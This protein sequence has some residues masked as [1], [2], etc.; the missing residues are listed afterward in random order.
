MVEAKAQFHSCS[1]RRALI[2]WAAMLLV[3]HFFLGCALFP[4]VRSISQSSASSSTTPK[5]TSTTPTTPPT[6]TTATT[7]ATT[8]SPPA[9]QC[10]AGYVAGWTSTEG[11]AIYGCH[12]VSANCKNSSSPTV[13]SIQ[14]SIPRPPPPPPPPPSPKPGT[15]SL[16]VTHNLCVSPTGAV[17]TCAAVIN[18]AAEGTMGVIIAVGSPAPATSITTPV[19]ITSSTSSS[20][21]P[22]V[23]LPD[24]KFNAGATITLRTQPLGGDKITLF[25]RSG[26][27]V[28]LDGNSNATA[29]E[30]TLTAQAYNHEHFTVPLFAGVA[31]PATAVG[32]PIANLSFETFAGAQV[33]N[34]TMGFTWAGAGL[35][36]GAISAS[37]NFTTVDPAIGTGI[38]YNLGTFSGIP[39][40]AWANV[41]IDRVVNSHTLNGDLSSSLTYPVHNS[42][43]FA[44]GLNFD[45][46]TSGA[47]APPPIIT[48]A[49]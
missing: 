24:A 17:V 23:D 21:D 42:T 6:T 38:A 9:L 27:L 2:G 8:T 28:P 37:G 47:P 16:P 20:N 13:Q 25:A 36:G 40:S 22:P 41:T 10:A 32:L 39:T 45:I 12:C 3:T 11:P 4:D 44:V 48:K 19:G 5:T 1:R 35:P 43:A 33:K 15:Q 7:T 14:E 31:I 18:T 30:A 29:S 46:P 49:H 34:R 26:I